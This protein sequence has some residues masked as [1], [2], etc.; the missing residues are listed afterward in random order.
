[1]SDT[2][3]KHEAMWDFLSDCP[4]IVNFLKFNSVED[5]QGEVSIATTA[6]E[7]WEKKY[8]RNHGIMRYDFALIFMQP[9]DM[10]TSSVNIDEIFDVQEVMTWIDKQNANSNFPNFGEECKMLSIE[11]LQNVPTLSAVNADN[12][13][14][15]YMLQCRVRYAI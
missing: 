6:T 5:T 7:K 13:V 1:M 8:V 3:N 9:H 14:A 2:I 15:K 10:G 11:N 12:S 4:L